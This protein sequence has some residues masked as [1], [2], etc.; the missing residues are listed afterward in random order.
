MKPVID[1]YL[2]LDPLRTRI[3]M[4]ERYSEPPIDIEVDVSETVGIKSSDHLLDVGSGTGSFL[5]RLN[6]SGHTGRL[7]A[8]DT[9]PA[10]IE[11]A[12]AIPGVEAVI[13]DAARLP[14]RDAQFDIVTARHMLY[15]VGTPADALLEARRVLRP[16]GRFAATVNHRGTTPGFF[17]VLRQVLAGHGLPDPV[18]PNELVNSDNLPDLVT[19]VFGHVEVVRRDNAL[20]V[21]SPE[22]VIA[23][24]ASMLTLSGV[25]ADS[26]ERRAVIA[27]LDAEVRRRFAAGGAPW[28]EPKGYVICVATIEGPGGS[29][30]RDG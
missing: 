2:H 19:D 14:Y 24:C 25:A 3:A 6:A 18:T 21:P 8:A 9:S 26:P 10:A 1:E 20:V 7:C 5:Q 13:A 22:P 30:R 4:H 29:G 16:G 12:S 17:E 23:Y 28:R 11:A 27:D 15:H